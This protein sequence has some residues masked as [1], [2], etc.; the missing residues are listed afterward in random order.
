MS[1]VNENPLLQGASGKFA[2]VV[3]YRRVRGKVVMAKKP[4]PQSPSTVTEKQLGIRKSFKK[5]AGYA[6]R[7]IAKPEVKRLYAEGLTPR[8]HNAYLV[9]VC[10]YLKVPEIVAVNL[11]AYTGTAGQT[12]LIEASDDFRVAAVSVAIQSADG[13]QIESGAANV[14]E[15]LS[16]DWSYVTTVDNATIA[17]TKVLV[18]VSDI[19]GNVTVAAF[20][21]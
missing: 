21:K 3:V 14:P 2:N 15:G 19:A 20:E 12:I 13:T 4:K 18:S 1:I 10:D 16:D 17:G 8:K 6:K 5:A 9:A 11:T 7:Q